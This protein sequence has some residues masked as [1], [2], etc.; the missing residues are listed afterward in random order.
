[1]EIIN[2]LD[3][4]AIIAVSWLLCLNL[5]LEAA[6]SMIRIV[7]K[8]LDL[9]REGISDTWMENLILKEMITPSWKW[10]GTIVW[11]VCNR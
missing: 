3:W 9:K 5:E 11:K 10:L 4:E 6:I 8:H 1:M 7:V 2:M